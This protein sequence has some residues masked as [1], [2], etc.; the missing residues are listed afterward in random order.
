MQS[1]GNNLKP[2]Q[3][4]QMTTTENKKYFTVRSY[5]AIKQK[6]FSIIHANIE[7]TPE[8]RKQAAEIY[9]PEHYFFE[10][11]NCKHNVKFCN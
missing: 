5:E 1:Q 2:K 11:H 8:K 10:Y 9:P 6:Q 7:N 3:K 4:K